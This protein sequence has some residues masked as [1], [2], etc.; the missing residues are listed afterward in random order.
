MV[1]A[2][3]IWKLLVAVKD[4]LALL[5]LLLFFM[6]LYAVLSM[7]PSAGSV[8]EGALLLQLD[9]SIVEEPAIPDPLAA[10]LSDEDLPTEY[11]AR[12]IVQSLRLAARDRRIKAVVLDLS[13]FVGGGLVHMQE[14]GAALDIVRAAKKPVLAYAPLYFD[15]RILLAAHAS[16]VWVD[17][18]GGAFISGPGGNRLYFASLLEKLK[19]TVHVFRVGTFKSAVE[20]YLRNDTSPAAREADQAL[21][22]SLWETWK[23]DVLKARPKTNI[24]LATGDPAG[25]LKVSGGNAAKAA[26]AAGLV[27]RIGDSVQFG[28]RV[29]ELAGADKSDK[30][31]GSFAHTSLETWQAASR[32]LKPGKTIGVVTI[33]GE[34]VDGKG[35]PG[36]AGGDRIVKLLDD[37][38]S[39]DFAALVVRVDSP[40]GSIQASERIRRAIE[41]YGNKK[42]PIVVSM[43]NMAASGG[44]WVSTPAQRIFAQP[45]T[46]TGS[47]GVFAVIPTFERALADWGVTSDGT[48]T[49]PLSGQPDALGGLSP[50]VS[51]MIQSNI[52]YDY[53]H[54]IDLVARA[55]GKTSQQVDRIGQGRVWNGGTA[56]QLGLVDEFGG[57]NEALAYAADAAKLAP[58]QWHPEFLGDG[59]SLSGLLRHLRGAHASDAIGAGGRAGGDWAAIAAQRQQGMIG[60][61]LDGVEHMVGTRGAQAYCLE[62]PAQP[63]ALLRARSADPGLLVRLLRMLEAD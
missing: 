47:I 27:D 29:A 15:D 12:D 63:A 20:P 13:G 58:G 1:F 7:R 17:P 16:E 30:T 18:L 50:E 4:A 60:A 5:F 2:R 25:W 22:G 43:A 45:G 31:P 49:T 14:I 19:V 48:R 3:S 52:E 33:A 28:Q 51:A 59:E 42:I 6:M 38:L 37:A 26:L 57:L 46:I 39:R 44:Y 11:R 56:R 32:E 55:R 54:F 9:G 21:Y 41:R 35:G 23:A 61:A 36:V 8:R 53:S 24:A 62:C 40:G 10:L 34:I